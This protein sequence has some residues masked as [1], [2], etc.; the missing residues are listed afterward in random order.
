MYNEELESLIEA[1][2]ADGTL[3]AKNKMI[4][5]KKAEALGVDL[6][7]LELVLSARLKKAQHQVQG[8][9][10][11][12]PQAAPAPASPAV[13][14]P[15]APTVVKP[16]IRKCPACGAILTSF[17]TVCPECGAELA[18]VKA[19]GALEKFTDRL[20]EIEGGRNY[21]DEAKSK[22]GCGTIIL[23]ILFYPI[24]ITYYLIKYIVA[25][26]SE[27]KFDGTDKRKQD[28]ILNTPVPNS[29]EDL[30]EFI[31]FCAT[32]VEALPL[33]KL[34]KPSSINVI[35]WNKI[36]MKKLDA[37]QIKAKIAMKN[38]QE[39]W[40]EASR[41]IAEAQEKVDSNNSGIK[42]FR[43]IGLGIFG[44]Y[45]LLIILGSIIG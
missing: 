19:S 38:D 21:E 44:V 40:K 14:A 20:F 45:I 1:A 15:A 28:L 25:M 4:I 33:M 42:K 26:N 39:S 6:D 34:L 41:V 12:P 5:F 35:G 17:S 18:G 11:A 27:P 9:A 30:L 36:W 16:Q 7:E 2:T 8:F 22:V 43:N 32:R 23:W 29:K 10:P 13:A 31:I 37:L 24:A 3:S